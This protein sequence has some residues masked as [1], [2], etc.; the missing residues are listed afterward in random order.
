MKRALDYKDE[1][2][3]IDWSIVHRKVQHKQMGIRVAYNNND[4]SK[5]KQL[6]DNLTRSWHARALAVHIVTTNK[7]G[8][9]P[10]VDMVTWDTPEEKFAAIQE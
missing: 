4:M 3:S 9:T 2:N 6:Q 8:K 10:G 7:G 1:W 5:V